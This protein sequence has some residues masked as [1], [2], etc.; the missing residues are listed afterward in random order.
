MIY[1]IL[2]DTHLGH[3]RMQEYASRPEGFEERIFA[4]LEVIKPEDV[5]IHLGDFCIR[6]DEYW[7]EQ[8][9][10]CCAAGKKWLLRGN[11][12]KKTTAWYLEHGWDCVATQ[13]IMRLH[14]RDLA[15]SHY[16]LPKG[17]W[18]LNIHG[19]LHNTRHRLRKEPELA[20]LI[21][22]AHWLVSIEE[23]DYQPVNLRKIVERHANPTLA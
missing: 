11:H 22:P 12:D 17:E 2:T 5:L 20:T 8:F 3:A 23:N 4:G 1:W 7:H 16:P 6:R 18:E 15:L 21:T 9:M 10:S 19:H 13:L 14:G